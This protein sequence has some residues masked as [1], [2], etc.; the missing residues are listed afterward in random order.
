MNKHTE[1]AAGR[2]RARPACGYLQSGQQPDATTL[3]A[4]AAVVAAA[5]TST[6]TSAIA[7]DFICRSFR[8]G[9]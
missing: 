6:G 2:S 8:K 1:R 4:A 5:A 7:F 9:G 3:V